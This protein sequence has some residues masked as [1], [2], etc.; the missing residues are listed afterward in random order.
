MA[1]SPSSRAGKVPEHRV[2]IRT[3]LEQRLRAQQRGEGRRIA[4]QGTDGPIRHSL[5]LPRCLSLPTVD[6]VREALHVVRQVAG[7][8]DDGGAEPGLGLHPRLRKPRVDEGRELVGRDLLEPHDRAGLVERPPGSE[9][10]LHQ[11]RLGPGEY[12]ADLA[13]V[14]HRRAHRVLDQSAVEAGNGLE[15]VERDDHL[16]AARLGE[17]RRQREDFLRQPPDVAIRA[18]GREG[19]GDR[20]ERR[21]VRRVADLGAGRSHRVPQPAPRA[22]APGFRGDQRARVALEERDVR[23][24]AADGDLD[25]QRAA[26]RH[27]RERA[28]DERRLAVAPRRDQEDLLG[29]GQIGD[30]PVELGDAIGEGRRRHDLAVDERVLRY[31]KHRNRYAVYRSAPTCWVKK[32][33]QGAFA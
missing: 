22:V 20:A 14:L 6:L 19:H 5:E 27:H 4:E 24:E 7:E 13:L 25:G 16:A 2:H 11:A 1:I 32:N 17:S 18:H 3:V 12:V 9:H 28:P 33:A 8:L 26:A 21:G 31:V 30:Q 10:A 29:R 15:L 23:A